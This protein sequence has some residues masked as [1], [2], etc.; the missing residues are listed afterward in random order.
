[1]SDMFGIM[2][3]MPPPLHPPSSAD[4]AIIESSNELRDTTT[5]R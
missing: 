1:M 2:S 4:I 5:P 3:L